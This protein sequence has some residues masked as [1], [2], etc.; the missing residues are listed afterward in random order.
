MHEFCES[1]KTCERNGI[2]PE[3]PPL[4]T[5]FQILGSF[6][7]QLWCYITLDLRGLSKIHIE[8]RLDFPIS[9]RVQRPINIC[10]EGDTVW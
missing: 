3:G 6:F 5:P 8:K 2:T 7:L 4:K 1:S 10:E 9:P